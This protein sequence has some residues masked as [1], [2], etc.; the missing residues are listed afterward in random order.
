MIIKKFIGK[1]EEEA[2]AAARKELGN[3]VVIMNVKQVKAT[4]IFAFLRPK[5]VEVTA[6]LEEEQ[7]KFSPV[8]KESD[9]VSA[10]MHPSIP[11]HSA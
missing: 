1:T 3:G 8:K 11:F 6:A 5:M 2:T 9:I 4:G 7:E 10:Y